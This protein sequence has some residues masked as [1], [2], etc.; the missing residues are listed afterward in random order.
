MV[1]K[2]CQIFIFATDGACVLIGRIAKEMKCEGLGRSERIYMQSLSLT[3]GLMH[4]RQRMLCFAAK[5]TSHMQPG[6]LLTLYSPI[7]QLRLF[8][9]LKRYNDYLLDSGIQQLRE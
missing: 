2:K 6:R 4:A 5:L 1:R 7:W 8:W 9:S 3:C